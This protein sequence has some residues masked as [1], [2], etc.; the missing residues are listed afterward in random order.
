MCFWDNLGMVV[1]CKKIYVVVQV[2]GILGVEFGNYNVYYCFNIMQDSV[3]I[4]FE[5]ISIYLY[6]KFFFL[7]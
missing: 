5:S 1:K 4:Q 6:F 2:Y 7:K 3:N